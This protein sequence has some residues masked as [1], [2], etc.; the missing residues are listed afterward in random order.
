MYVLKHWKQEKCFI[1]TLK[2][3]KPSLTVKASFVSSCFSI[4]DFLFTT[5]LLF[6][7]NKT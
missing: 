5:G 1:I 3:T 7:E 2:E 6:T 4:F